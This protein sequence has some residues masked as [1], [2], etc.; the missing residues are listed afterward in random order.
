MQAFKANDIV[1]LNGNTVPYR[2]VSKNEMLGSYEVVKVVFNGNLVKDEGT[3]EHRMAYELQ[4][5][6][7]DVEVVTI[8]PPAFAYRQ[9]K[10]FPSRK[11]K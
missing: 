1:Y 3:V 11:E 7:I 9:L 6:T 8:R 5:S 10:P 4:K 2:I